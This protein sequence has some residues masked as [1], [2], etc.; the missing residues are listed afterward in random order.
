MHGAAMAR[1]AGLGLGHAMAQALGGRFGVSQEPQNAICLPPAIRFTEPAA[2]EA[3]A[4]LAAALAHRGCGRAC[5]RSWRRSADS[6]CARDYGIPEADLP[7]VAA[8]V[9]ARPATRVNPRPVSIDEALS[10]LRHVW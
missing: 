10:V 4:K 2:P 8:A 6:R 3:V 5:S 9:V 7:G 1:G